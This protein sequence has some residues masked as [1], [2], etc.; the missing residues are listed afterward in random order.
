MLQKADPVHKLPEV[1]ISY[2]AFLNTVIQFLVVAFVVFLMIKLISSVRREE[3]KQPT[4]PPAPTPTETLL[5]E[6]RDL[7]KAEAPAKGAE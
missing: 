2:G 6:I 7:L 1:A 5:A 4:P 3:A